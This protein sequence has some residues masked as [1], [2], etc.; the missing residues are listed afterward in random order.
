MHKNFSQAIDYFTQS[1]GEF[2]FF[3]GINKSMG[4]LYALL[5]A[6]DA[7]MSLDDMCHALK[8]SRGNASMNIRALQNWGVIRKVRIKGDR[9]DYYELDED[10][11]RTISMFIRERKKRELEPALTTMKKSANLVREAY[12]SMNVSDRKRAGVFLKR[13]DAMIE[14]SQGVNQ[15]LD[16]FIRGEEVHSS[17][18]TKIPIRWNT[19]KEA[20]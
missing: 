18:I 4:E 1:W 15:L 17:E 19:V 10:M 7:P 8:I 14:I 20:G 3:W 9:K 5:F 16:Q 12:K 13:L 2:G 11:W 6:T